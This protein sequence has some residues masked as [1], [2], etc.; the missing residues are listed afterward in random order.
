MAKIKSLVLNSRE[1]AAI[2]SQSAGNISIKG[3]L[4][5]WPGT[6]GK[7]GPRNAWRVPASFIAKRFGAS[8]RE[9]IKRLFEGKGEA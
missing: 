3:R 2:T 5:K 4:E 9:I 7:L 8:Q 6:R 1:I